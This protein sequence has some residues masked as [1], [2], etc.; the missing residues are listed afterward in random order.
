M[1]ELLEYDYSWN[2]KYQIKE[3]KVHIKLEINYNNVDRSSKKKLSWTYSSVQ[4]T[5]WQGVLF[6]SFMSHINRMAWYAKLLL[7]R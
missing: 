2:Y 1:L 3:F 6:W 4:N 7:D 5:I